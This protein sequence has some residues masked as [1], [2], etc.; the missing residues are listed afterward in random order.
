MATISLVGV[1]AIEFEAQATVTTDTGDTIIV[2]EYLPRSFPG[3][4]ITVTGPVA[5]IMDNTVAPAGKILQVFV[6][7]RVVATV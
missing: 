6:I 5:H 7:D 2:P 4:E 3:S 1:H